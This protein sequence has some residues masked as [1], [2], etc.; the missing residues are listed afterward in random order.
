MPRVKGR[1]LKRSPYIVSKNG[2]FGLKVSINELAGFNPG[3][4]VYQEQMDDGTILLIPEKI[5]LEDK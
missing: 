3:D 4:K 2:E 5:Y 1:L